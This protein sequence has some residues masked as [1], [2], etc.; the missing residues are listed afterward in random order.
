MI[1]EDRLL[2]EVPD[3][4][5][6]GVVLLYALFHQLSSV[7]VCKN[8]FKVVSSSDLLELMILK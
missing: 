8:Y 6:Y 1:V 5:V 2:C 4:N 3:V 7:E